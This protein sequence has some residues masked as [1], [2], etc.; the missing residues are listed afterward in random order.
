MGW[1]KGLATKF[2][3]LSELT[4]TVD[5]DEPL[6]GPVKGS[7]HLWREDTSRQFAMIPVILDALTAD[8]LTAA[9]LPR[10]GAVRFVLFHFALSHTT[11][12]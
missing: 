1:I 12:R 4:T 9:R 7:L 6:D 5:G 3:K 2:D 8:A 11:S 10:A